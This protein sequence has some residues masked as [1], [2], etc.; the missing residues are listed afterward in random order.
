MVV[1]ET[2][3]P[4]TIGTHTERPQGLVEDQVVYAALAAISQALERSQTARTKAL[5]RRELAQ[6]RGILLTLP[7]S[8]FD[9]Q[10]GLQHLIGVLGQ[11][12]LEPRRRRSTAPPPPPST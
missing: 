6:V 7:H 10:G 1:T 12:I 2:I 5:R 4:D 8:G 11:P 3:W 9:L